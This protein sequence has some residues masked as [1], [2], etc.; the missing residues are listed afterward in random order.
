MYEEAIEL[1]TRGHEVTVFTTDAFESNRRY[2]GPF[3]SVEDGVSVERFRNVSNRLAY[4][5]YRFLP[6]GMRAALRNV[7]CDVVHLSE[8]RHELA[9]LTWRAVRRR[10]L[11][12][13]ISAHGTL[14][15]GEGLKGNLKRSYDSLWVTPMLA[16]AR[17]VL[18]QTTHEA[19]CY[20]R[21]GVPD[22]RIHLLPLGTAE[23]PE[24]EPAA[25]GLDP[26][27]RVVLF[28]GRLHPLKGVDRLVRG[29]AAVHRRH[30]DAVLVIVGRDD[31]A[32]IDLRRM[33]DELDLRGKVL[34]PGPI[35]GE[36]RFAAYRRA[37]LFAITPRH[38][39]ETSLAAIEAASVGT[40][41]L[42]GDEAE[43]PFLESYGAGWRVPADGDVAP[44][45]DDALG[46]DLVSAGIGAKKMIEERHLWP[47]VGEKLELILRAVSTT[48][49][50][51]AV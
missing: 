32:E 43:A 13:V 35:F 39:E 4:S 20:R 18:A 27:R 45:L 34:F 1:V 19:D 17:A 8:M 42:L 25:L 26:D 29:F 50:P 49:P 31:G 41:L 16:H 37:S 5:R 9:V 3:P 15:S 38:F 22:E 24:G 2:E 10:G 30:S 40:A 46:G 7:D 28:V 47:V 48:W 23:P 14:P 11:P 44:I 21:A 36:D 51:R 6:V 12:L 33:V